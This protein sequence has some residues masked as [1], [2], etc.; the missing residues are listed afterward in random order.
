MVLSIQ[1][2]Q[3]DESDE[4]DL[5]APCKSCQLNSDESESWMDPSVNGDC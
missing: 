4:L 2:D 1:L 5:A 3:L